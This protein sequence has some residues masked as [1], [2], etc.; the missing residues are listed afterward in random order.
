[1]GRGTWPSPLSSATQ[2]ISPTN[3]HESPLATARAVLD[4][5]GNFRASHPNSILRARRAGI[6]LKKRTFKFWIVS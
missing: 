1:M 6:V 2:I 4:Y 5:P 3:F